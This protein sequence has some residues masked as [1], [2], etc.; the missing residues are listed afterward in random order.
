MSRQ[1]NFFFPQDSWQ[2]RMIITHSFPTC[3]VR[4]VR[5]Y[6]SCPASSRRLLLLLLRLRWTSTASARSQW[7]P[8][9]PNSKP[10]IRVVPA[11]PQPQRISEEI[12]D[13]MPERLSEDLPDRKPG[14]RGGAD[15]SDEIQM[16]SELSSPPFPRQK[17]LPEKMPEYMPDRMSDRMFWWG[18]LDISNARNHRCGVMTTTFWWKQLWHHVQG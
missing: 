8:P 9:D 13:R 14:G 16:P 12:S 17:V 7:S 11:G 5:F 10:R 2:L 4:V 18:S 6:V 3:Q 15:D 1:E